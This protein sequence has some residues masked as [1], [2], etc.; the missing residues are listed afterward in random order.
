MNPRDLMDV[1]NGC[2][3]RFMIMEWLWITP[4]PNLSSSGVRILPPAVAGVVFL[5]EISR[6]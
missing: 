1:Y 2:D 4:A 3:E 5:V 6:R